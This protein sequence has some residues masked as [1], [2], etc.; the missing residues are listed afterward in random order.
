MMRKIHSLLVLIVFLLYANCAN[1]DRKSGTVL[2]N[3]DIITI[4]L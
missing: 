2:Q 4:D 1:N 3:K